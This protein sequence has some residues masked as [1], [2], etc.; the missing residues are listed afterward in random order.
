MGAFQI[1]QEFQCYIRNGKPEI[2]RKMQ[3]QIL[4]LKPT[5]RQAGFKFFNRHL[6]IQCSLS[7]VITRL[8]ADCQ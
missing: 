4:D 6:T 2:R 5:Y 3:S 8:I 1:S 7:F